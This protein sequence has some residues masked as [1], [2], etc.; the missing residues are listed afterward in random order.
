VKPKAPGIFHG[1]C[2]GRLRALSIK[3]FSMTIVLIAVRD[4]QPDIAMARCR[5]HLL[6]K[7]PNQAFAQ[8][9]CRLAWQV[10]ERDP[11]RAD[12]I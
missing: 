7:Y 11:L 10:G 1:N 8:M 3:H 12:A 9:F 2:H 6:E 5:P 4:Q